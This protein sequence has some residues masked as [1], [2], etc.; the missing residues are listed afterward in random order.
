MPDGSVEALFSGDNKDDVGNSN[1]DD[2]DDFDSYGSDDDDGDEYDIIGKYSS[3]KH[4]PIFCDSSL[5][6]FDNGILVQPVN[7]LS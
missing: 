1:N 6:L 2:D 4:L 5:P 7:L 3:Y